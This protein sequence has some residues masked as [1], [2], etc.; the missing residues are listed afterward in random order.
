[1]KIEVDEYDD[2]DAHCNNTEALMEINSVELAVSS[3]KQAVALAPDDQGV[4]DALVRA[5]FLLIATESPMS[6]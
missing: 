2:A 4:Y 6:H 3:Y 1:M 5:Q